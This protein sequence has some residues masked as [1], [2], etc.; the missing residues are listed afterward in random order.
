MTSFVL[1]LLL[2]AGI[3]VYYARPKYF[4]LYWLAIQPYILPVFFILF[5]DSMMPMSDNYLPNLYFGYPYPF[6]NLILLFFCVT[7]VKDNNE[8]GPFRVIV[9]SLLYLL[10]FLAIQNA[11][12]GFRPGVLYI[13]IINVF[14]NIAPFLLILINKEVRPKR[15]SF[16]H[17]IFVFVYIQLFFSLLNLA[18]IRIYRDVSGLYDDTLI[19]GTFTRYNHMANYLSIFFF[20]L[21]Y[22]YY[23]CKRL[24]SKTYYIMAFLIGLLI[25]LS[26]SRMTFILFVFTFL[27]FFCISHGKKVAILTSLG[28]VSLFSVFV[29]GNETFWGQKAEEGTGLERNLIGVIDLANSDDLS[30]GSTLAL[31]AYLLMDK[32]NSPLIGNGKAFRAENFYGHP[33]DTW[34]EDI[35]RTDARLAF[36][37]V[38]YGIVGLFFFL[39]LYASVFK[40][41]SKFSDENRKILYCGAFLYFI[42][43]SLTDNG[44]WDNVVLSVLFIYVFSVKESPENSLASVT[45]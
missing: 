18:D 28:A 8:R 17:F 4:F 42:L 2:M 39:L 21:T 31:S 3:V 25:A 27:F 1:L 40:G 26:G 11:L 6:C 23:V 34:N 16:I 7:Y 19:A 32:F 5:K 24:S 14:E 37:L 15:D 36:M 33:T 45:C 35:Y 44:F 12:I 29:M 20:V 30:E 10:F 43:F 41:C 9:K 13:N 38:E 22:E